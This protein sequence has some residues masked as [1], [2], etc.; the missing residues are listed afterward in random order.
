MGHGWLAD[1]AAL[2]ARHHGIFSSRDAARLDVSRRQLARATTAGVLVRVHPDVFA[3]SATPIDRRA[4]I[5]ASVMQLDSG[6]AS[7]ESALHL[8]GVDRIPDQTAVTIPRGHGSHTLDRVRVHRARDLHPE[9]LKTVEG[10]ATTTVER[11]IVDVTSIFS[12]ARLEYLLDHLTITRRATSVG[13][14]ARTLRQVNRKGRIGIAAL[15][16]LLEQRSP[17]EPAPRSRLERRVDDLL[18]AAALPVAHAEHPLPSDDGVPRLCGSRLAGGE[19][20]SRD[21]WSDLACEGALDGS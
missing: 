21:R 19:A 17:N 10:I 4:R 6:V 3:F 12:P 1:V 13:A 8:H 11:A 5:A 14:I 7:H 9:H 2:A 16:R 20:H 18:A 15:P